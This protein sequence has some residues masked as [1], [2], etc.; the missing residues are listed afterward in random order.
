[1]IRSVI[2]YIIRFIAVILLPAGGM[3]YAQTVPI[4]TNCM[5]ATGV[6]TGSAFSFPAGVNSGTAEV[7]A[8]YGCL[9]TQPNPAWFFFQM[10]TNGSIRIKMS[11]SPSKDIDFILWGPFTDPSLPCVTGLTAAK[12]TDCSYSRN[13]TEYADISSGVTGEYYVMLITNYSNQN[14]NITFSQTSGTG[15]TNCDILCNIG[16]ITALPASCGTGAAKGTYSLNGTVSVFSPPSSGTLT[17]TSSCG[18]TA[19]YNT[20]FSTS[21]GY[22]IPGIIGK[23]DSCTVTATFSAV[24]TCTK[25]YKYLA[26]ACCALTVTDTAIKVCAGQ[27]IQFNSSGTTG[28]V[29]KWTGPGGFTSTQQSPSIPNAAAAH[30]GLYQVYLI[31]G[32]CTTSTKNINVTV[33]PLPSSTVT[34]TRDTSFC[35]GDSVIFTGPA[36]PAGS[37]YTYQWKNASGNIGGA[38]AITYIAKTSGVYS[39]QVKDTNN[40][41]QTSTATT[42]TIK[43]NPPAP[44]AYVSSNTVCDGFYETFYTTSDPLATYQW[45]L[46]GAIIH[47]SNSARLDVSTAGNYS[48]KVTKNGCST[49]SNNLRLTVYARPAPGKKIIHR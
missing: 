16:S 14:T 12:I 48:V 30:A 3:L 28:G 32:S 7:G 27:T 11:S 37:V 22:I 8:D 46:D 34:I 29:Y 19:T 9:T 21:V 33:R 31:N 49:T 25:T 5:G 24:S 2:I 13:S 20:P 18:G 10:K 43:T 40:C 36:S 42:V 26:P 15:T 4:S 44:I 47:G 35:P 23:G 38:T 41:T 1:M 17:V 45:Y 6:C 39:L